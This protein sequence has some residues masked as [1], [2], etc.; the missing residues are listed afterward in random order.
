MPVI[1]LPE[2]LMPLAGDAGVHP[3]VGD[4]H[5]HC[6]L[7]YGHGSLTDALE[8]SRRQLDFVSVTGHANRPDMP[9]DDPSIAHIIDFHVKGF[10]R[11][12]DQ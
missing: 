10:A 9:V 8:N 1:D 4:L 6:N 5:N 7:S 11:L 2:R 12:K 3:Y